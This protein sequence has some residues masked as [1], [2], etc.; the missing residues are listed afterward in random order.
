M[1]IKQHGRQYDLVVFGA[2][3]YTGK[4]TA[5]YVTT[6]LPTDLK[7]AIAGRSREKL[8]KIAAELKSLNADRRQPDIEICDLDDSELSKLSKKTFILITTVGPYGSYGEH[9]FKACAENGTHYLDVT[10]EVPFSARMIKRYEKI[11]KASGSLMFPQIGIESAPPDLI[12]WTLAKKIRDELSAKTGDTTVSIHKLDTAPSGGTMASVLGMFDVFSLK[13]YRDAVR[14]F[15]LSPVPNPKASH[16]FSV[17]GALAGI[18]SVPH[19]GV[20]TTCVAG[21]TDS[22]MVQRTW[23]LLSSTPSRKDE[24]Y[25]P[26]FT[27]SEYMKPKNWL[28]G[29]AMHWGLMFAQLFLIIPVARKAARRFA[30][31]P[32][33]GPDVEQ[34]KK[35]NLEFRG[36]ARPDLPDSKSKQAYCRASYTGGM[37]YLTAML[38]AEGA[39]TLLQDDLEL[40]GGIYTAACMGQGYI[41][42]LNKCG[43]KFETKIVG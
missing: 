2:T 27:F 28:H 38:L 16:R 32:G 34:T 18:R 20:Q 25:G 8:E 33:L 21:E 11:A 5:E 35:Q 10:G 23:G 6:N 26:N 39:E 4:I 24:F 40:P 7:W 14:P 1:P 43:F 30:L 12:T 9:A 22:A 41:D 15:A 13:E 29:I 42:R 3:G 31:Q 17:V 36:V 19:L 37:Y